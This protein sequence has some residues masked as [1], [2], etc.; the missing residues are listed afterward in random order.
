MPSYLVESYLSRTCRDGMRLVAL[1]AA[2]A[3]AALAREGK[4]VQYLR[5]SFVPDDEVCLHWFTAS[6][7]AVVDEVAERAALAW[8]RVVEAVE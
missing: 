4:D 8:D 3:A 2:R 7:A 1:R 5:S 6:S